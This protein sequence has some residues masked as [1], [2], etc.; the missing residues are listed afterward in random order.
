MDL[1]LSPAEIR[2]LGSLIEK[3]A[4]TPENYPLSLNALKNACNQKTS[5][6]P[7]VTYNDEAIRQ[8]LD[9]LRGKNLVFVVYGENRVARYGQIL[10]T[11]FKLEHSELS[12]LCVLMLRGPQTAGEIRQHAAPLHHYLDLADVERA[13][14]ALIERDDQ[15]LA[16]KLPRAMGAKESRYAHLLSGLVSVPEEVNVQPARPSGARPSRAASPDK[17]ERLANLEGKT[18]ALRQQLAELRQQFIDLKKQFE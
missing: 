2:V 17:S 10:D 6:D 8:A 5:R 11:V 14:V 7:V 9:G 4:T 13:L 16:V 1:I 3:Q 15:S 12:A 18:A